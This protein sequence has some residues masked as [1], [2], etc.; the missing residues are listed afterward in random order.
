MSAAAMNDEGRADARNESVDARERGASSKEEG[1]NNDRN[2][3]EGRKHFAEIFGFD[4][5]DRADGE[6][7]PRAR[8]PWISGRKELATDGHR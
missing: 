8:R 7:S 5:R 1:A 6:E 3:S 2:K 4:E